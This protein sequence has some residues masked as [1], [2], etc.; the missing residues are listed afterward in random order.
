MPADRDAC[1]DLAAIELA[2]EIRALRGV[3]PAPGNAG[4]PALAD[5][6]TPF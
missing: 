4:A 3:T 6:D 1:L 2:E 5:V